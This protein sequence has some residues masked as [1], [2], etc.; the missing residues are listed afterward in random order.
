VELDGKVAIVTGAAVGIG[1]AVAAALAAEGAD[2]VVADVD[3][4]M[5]R[6]AA[7][8]LGGR[9]VLADVLVDEDLR[10]L[11]GGANGLAVLVNNAGGAPEPHYPQAPVEHWTRTLELNLRSVML[12]TQ[13]AL[14]AMPD[15]GAIVNVASMAGYGLFPHGA[16]EYAAAKAGI[17]RLTGALSPLA[18]Q[19][20]VRINCICPD[21]VDT[22]AVHRSLAAM[23]E[24]ERA[25]VPELVPADEIASL[26]LDLI[27]DD[28]LAGRV[29]IRPADGPPELMPLEGPCG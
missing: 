20:A 29:M 5:G 28:S 22:P 11:I 14:E 27:R 10:R 16:P 9:F 13:L 25:Q 8:E 21:W 4:E 6:R 12:A 24:E 23:S 15:G 18:E 17:M 26:V 1:R 2:V 3:A 19:T 7:R